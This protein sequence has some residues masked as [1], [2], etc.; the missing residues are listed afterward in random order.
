[1]LLLLLL[2]PAL[3]L[4]LLLLML[5]LLLLGGSRLVPE[6]AAAAVPTK[7]VIVLQTDLSSFN[8]RN[9]LLDCWPEDAEAPLVPPPPPPPPPTLLAQERA[10]LALFQTE[11]VARFMS[12]WRAMRSCRENIQFPV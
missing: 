10:E 12:F 3:L 9:H 2:A 1:M 6:A 8:L 5:L 7:I 4:L 11:P